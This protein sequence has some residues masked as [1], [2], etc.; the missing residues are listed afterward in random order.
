MPTYQS[1]PDVAQFQVIYTCDSQRV[2][3]DFYF[4]KEG[5]WAEGD[6]SAANVAILTEWETDWKPLLPTTIELTQVIA[7]G[8]TS[9]SSPRIAGALAIPIAGTNVSPALPLNATIAV[10]LSTAVRGRGR[11]GRIFWPCLTEASVAGDQ[12]G[13]VAGNNIIA[14]VL[15]LQAAVVA[16]G[17]GITP[18]VVHRYLDRVKIFPGTSDPIVE[19]MLS[20]NYVD[21]QKDRLPFHKKHKKRRVTP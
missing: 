8:L 17:A 21:S 14:A 1:I 12:V 3:N 16:S 18:V 7:T 10:K 20:D 9:L 11:N 4:H 6:L 2:Q 5:D 13:E 19:V 15:A